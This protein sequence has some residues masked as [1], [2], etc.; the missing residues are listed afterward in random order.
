MKVN[1]AAEY[2]RL[3]AE[4]EKELKP[5]L[6]KEFLAKLV[7]AAKVCGWGADHIEI[8]GFVYWCFDIAEEDDSKLNL[9]PYYYDLL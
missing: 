8:T 3:I 4:K 5:L 9:T 2:D 7:E 6:D 1:L